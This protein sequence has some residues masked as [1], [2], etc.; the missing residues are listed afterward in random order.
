MAPSS[1][2]VPTPKWMRGTSEVGHG[3]EHGRP[4]AVRRTPGSRRSDSAPAQESNSWIAEAPAS[5]CIRRY[6]PAI[7]ASRASKACHSSGSRY[8]SSL[9]SRWSRDGPPFDEVRRQGERRAGEPDQ[10]C[11]AELADQCLGGIGDARDVVGLEVA[12]LVELVGAAE[13]LGDDRSGAGHDVEID[14]DGLERH[15]DVGE[16]DRRVDAVPAH[17][18]HRDLDDQSVR[19][20]DSS[21]GT[22]S[23]M[24]RYSGSER[25]AWRMNHTGT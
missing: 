18:L 8:I 25:P 14:A 15:D 1:S 20:H 13:R 21:I 6:C 2:P 22:P 7:A 5:T 24:A 4:S 17:R 19:K 12:Q 16:E 10:R 23:R 3:G 9:V 11:A